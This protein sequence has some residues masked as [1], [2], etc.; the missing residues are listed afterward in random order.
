V[1]LD[2]SMGGVVDVLVR[3]D[4][5]SGLQRVIRTGTRT[6][7]DWFVDD[8]GHVN[9]LVDYDWQRQQ[10]KLSTV[11]DEDITP[12]LTGNSSIEVPGVVGFGADASTVLVRMLQDNDVVYRSLAV[13][14]GKLSE[15]G[16]LPDEATPMFDPYT[17]RLMGYSGTAD[18]RQLHFSDPERQNAWE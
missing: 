14:T 1:K 13:G 7:A 3:Y 12:V 4:L 9:A 8:A 5:D 11:V 18:S 2:R 17:R 15:A 16:M 10:W 6:T